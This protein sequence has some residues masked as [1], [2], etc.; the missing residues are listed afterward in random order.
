MKTVIKGIGCVHIHIT[1][2]VTSKPG[3]HDFGCSGI[4]KY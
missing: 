4:L 2:K 1:N 3:F